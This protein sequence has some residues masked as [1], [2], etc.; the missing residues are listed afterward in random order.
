MSA[1]TIGIIGGGQLGRMLAIAAARLNFRTIILEPQADCPAAQLANRQIVAAYDDPAALAELAAACDLVTYEFENVPVAAAETLAERVPVYPPAKALEAAQDRLVEKRFLNGCGISTARE[2]ALQDFGGQGV[3][4]TRRLGYDGKGQK[5][6]RSAADS[7]D[8][9][10][11]ALGAVPLIL[12]SFV[13]FE[14]EIS[15]I[16][17]RATDGAVVCFDPAE[18]V[19]RDGILHTS[20][21]PAAIP[22]ATADAAR[23]SAEKILAAL[24][25]VGVIGIEFFVLADGSLIAN[26]MAPRVHN[27]GHWT[28]AACVVSQFEQHIRAV[29]GLPL[30]NAERHS[31]CVMQ[32]LIGDD[33]LAV[34]D[35]LRRAD[36]LVHLY[37]KSEWRPGRKMGH[38]TTLTSKSPISS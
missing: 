10:Y 19:H 37:G 3:L 1:G 27:S 8:G 11:A 16:A 38:V 15:I 22:E 24:N 35:W 36:T 23:R 26:E 6:F 4:K 30:G 21:V 20:T 12:E 18:N 17:A 7:P 34:P 29:A 14:R 33:I 31:D 5:V 25:Y 28:E 32:N 2:A 13:A 9:A